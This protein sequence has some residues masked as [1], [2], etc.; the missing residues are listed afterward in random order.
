VVPRRSLD[1]LKRDRGRSEFDEAGE[2]FLPDT[3]RKEL[4]VVDLGSRDS[5]KVFGGRNVLSYEGAWTQAG[6]V[7]IRGERDG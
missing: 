3:T 2:A 7:F 6:I 5:R 1:P 4:R